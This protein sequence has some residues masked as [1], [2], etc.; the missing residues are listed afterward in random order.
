MKA[1]Y[2]ALIA[3][4]CLVASK[5]F[6]KN[7]SGV[8]NRK[9]QNDTGKTKRSLARSVGERMVYAFKFYKEDGM[10]CDSIPDQVKGID[11]TK[12]VSVIT[13]KKGTIIVQWT[14]LNKA[15]GKP[16]IGHYCTL[17]GADPH[18]LGISLEGR[19]K[20]TLVLTQDTKFLRS[21]ASDI[22]DWHPTGKIF[23]GGAVQLFQEHINY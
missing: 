5:D 13:L 19:V 14:H 2:I 17:P 18:K 20:T 7:N 11:L 15:N 12:P 22:T 8:A 6:A 4:S 1:L 10:A 16:I 23:K 3:L 9:T 21:I